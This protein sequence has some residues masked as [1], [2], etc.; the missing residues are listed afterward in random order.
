MFCGAPGRPEDVLQRQRAKVVLV[1]IF[2]WNSAQ[3]LAGSEAL[4]SPHGP[5]LLLL[6]KGCCCLHLHSPQEPSDA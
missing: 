2:P 5:L 1:D 6:T 3:L 4:L